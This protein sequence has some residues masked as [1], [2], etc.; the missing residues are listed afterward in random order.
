MKTAATPHAHS[1]DSALLTEVAAG[2]LK[3]NKTLPCK[4]FYDERG[5]Q[6]FERICTLPEYYPTRTELQILR[7]HGRDMA[8]W[9]GSAARVVEFGSGSG[10]KTRVLLTHAREVTEYVPIDIAHSQ[11]LAF[12]RDLGRTLPWL[13]V[14][15]V[16]ADY[17][18]EL[19]LPASARPVA[20]TVVFFPGSTIGNF[21]PA[22]ARAFLRNAAAICGRGGGLLIGVDLRK[23]RATLERA[24]NDAQGI[25]AAF[26]LNLLT[27]INRVC[28]A[29]FDVSAF[30]HRAIYD[31]ARG[32]IEMHLVSRAPQLV[33]LAR[34]LPRPTRVRFA[35][36]EVMLTEYSYK[37][38]ITGFQ[39]LAR[40]AGFAP[41]AVWTDPNH[42]F[43][44]HAFD[45]L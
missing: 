19:T 32:R 29:D 20:R 44:V 23:D 31:E 12:A 21:E 35:A 6:L 18:R 13:H 22:D 17:T 10:E 9:I 2:L 28:D 27:H 37:Y 7:T 16:C 42:R 30:A 4:L 39:S 1:I 34:S 14:R 3:P 15:P 45:A 43:S 26:N 8:A 25:T 33:T 40:Q 24:Y 11:L 41:A 5:A 38:D 36:G